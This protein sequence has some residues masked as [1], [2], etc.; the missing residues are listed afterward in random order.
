MRHSYLYNGN[1]YTLFSVTVY[2]KWLYPTYAV[3]YVVT[4]SCPNTCLW[5]TSYHSKSFFGTIVANHDVSTFVM[6]S[7]QSAIVTARYCIARYFIH[8]NCKSRT[9]MHRVLKSQQRHHH[10]L[11]SWTSYGV[12]IVFEKNERITCLKRQGCPMLLMDQASENILTYLSKNGGLGA[13]QIKFQ[14]PNGWSMTVIERKS[15]WKLM[16]IHVGK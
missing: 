15:Y 5:H 10:I 2:G 1:P 9:S 3:V 14:I 4:Y 8:S 12:P 16:P 6:C 7:I 11:L 13:R